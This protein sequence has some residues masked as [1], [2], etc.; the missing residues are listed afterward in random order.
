MSF[1]GWAVVDAE[2]SRQAD[3]SIVVAG[4]HPFGVIESLSPAC[5]GAGLFRLVVRDVGPWGVLQGSE[6]DLS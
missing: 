3:D 4:Y 6:A 1:V 2:H 5:L